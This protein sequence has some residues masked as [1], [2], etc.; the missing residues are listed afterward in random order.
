MESSRDIVVFL[1]LLNQR[2][3]KA[4]LNIGKEGWRKVGALRRTA[5]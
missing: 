4:R 5:P 1:K 3:L 2:L